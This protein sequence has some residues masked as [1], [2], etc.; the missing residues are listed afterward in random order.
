MLIMKT[1]RAIHSRL[2]MPATRCDPDN[3]SRRWHTLLLSHTPWLTAWN[4]QAVDIF[5]RRE[6]APFLP[7]WSEEY[8]AGNGKDFLLLWHPY[9]ASLQKL[10]RQE[11]VWRGKNQSPHRLLVSYS[12]QGSLKTV[13]QSFA[14]A[15]CVRQWYWGRLKPSCLLGFSKHG[16]FL[17]F[18]SRSLS[19]WKNH[20]CI[21][22]LWAQLGGQPNS[23]FPSLLCSFKHSHILQLTPRSLCSNG[24][25]RPS[26]RRNFLRTSGADSMAEPSLSPSWS[27]FCSS[28][29][30]EK[31]HS[32]VRPCRRCRYSNG[33]E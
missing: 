25:P 11:L 22:S 15:P 3:L 20:P 14:V 16:C 17:L 4:G 5:F 27:F 24:C 12:R 33:R 1:S 8:L 13:V 7:V 21:S 9:A 26:R 6:D 31:D 28:Y 29:A 2:Q 30:S 10:G 23:P 18:L 32:S 19:S